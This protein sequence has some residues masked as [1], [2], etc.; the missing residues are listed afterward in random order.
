MHIDDF[1]WLPDIVDKLA[2]KHS[3]SIQEVEQVLA[4]LPRIRQQEAGHRPGEDV[5]AA[6][7][8][9]NEGRYLV[10]FFILKVKNLALVISGRDMD[11]SERRRYG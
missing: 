10:V 8:R 1:V 11:E 7:G 9:T 6:D 3:I 2:S 5:Y 4:N